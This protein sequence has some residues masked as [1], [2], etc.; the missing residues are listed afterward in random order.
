MVF[1]FFLRYF[2]FKRHSHREEEIQRELLSAISLPKW[3]HSG[4]ILHCFYM[5]SAELDQK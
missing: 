2:L 5:L 1:F 3:V 4:Y